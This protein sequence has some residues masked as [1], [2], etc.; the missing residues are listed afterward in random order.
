MLEV[1]NVQQFHRTSSPGAAVCTDYVMITL[2][3]KEHIK[4]NSTYFESI[5]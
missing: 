2:Q 3:V 5:E 4:V 1:V